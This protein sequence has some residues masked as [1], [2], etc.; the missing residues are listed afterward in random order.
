MKAIVEAGYK[1]WVAH[2]FV[3]RR[4]PLKSLEQGIQICDV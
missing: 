4:D 1:G 3:P 2:E